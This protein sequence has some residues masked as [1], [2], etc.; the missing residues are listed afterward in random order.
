MDG[1]GMEFRVI[2]IDLNRI[3]KL[4]RRMMKDEKVEK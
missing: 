1:I 2:R 3:E 4:R